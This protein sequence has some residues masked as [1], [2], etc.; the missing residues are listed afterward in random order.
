MGYVWGHFDKSCLWQQMALCGIF[1]DM[2][3]KTKLWD[4]PVL[5]CPP[6]LSVWTHI[7]R[8]MHEA[9]AGAGHL[10]EP[11][12]CS[13]WLVPGHCLLSPGAPLTV[14]GG[15]HW[16]GW[17]EG[18]GGNSWAG[19]ERDSWELSSQASAW[20]ASPPPQPGQRA[21]DGDMKADFMNKFA[22]ADK[23]DQNCNKW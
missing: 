8:I 1:N 22:L 15:W 18:W 21:P 17:A 7:C 4:T 13:H 6:A 10:T 12:K 20:N 5:Q 9:E 23:A 16:R 14:T 3:I 2:C 19:R 11:G